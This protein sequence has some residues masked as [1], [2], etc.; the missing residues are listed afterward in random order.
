MNPG[1]QQNQQKPNFERIAETVIS[2]WA[3]G[4]SKA[5]D[6]V[7]NSWIEKLQ[8]EW[9]SIEKGK[10]SYPDNQLLEDLLNEYHLEAYL[11][12]FKFMGYLFSHWA[13]AMKILNSIPTK[14][15]FTKLTFELIQALHFLMENNQVE[16]QIKSKKLKG[17]ISI[18]DS[19]LI[20]II[21]QSLFEFYKEHKFIDSPG[22]NQEEISDWG[23]HIEKAFNEIKAKISKK[24]R[25][26]GNFQIK[27]ITFYLWKYLQD[28]TEIKAEEGAESSR[29]QSRFIFRFLEI[30]GIIDNPDF[31]RKEDN[32]S[33]Y[34]KAYKESRIRN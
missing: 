2:E 24:G 6:S 26:K 9:E 3:S 13:E 4:N 23:E 30:Y 28:N 17:G 29:E 5:H 32:I 7:I 31:S 21:Q 1:N 20:Q 18:Q 8:K 22:N 33:Y 14:N 10:I 12:D 25:K 16:I 15:R 27:R 11:P 19:D 34:L